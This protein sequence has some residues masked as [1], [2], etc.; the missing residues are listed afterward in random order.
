MLTTILDLLGVA[1]LGV[2]AW[3]VWPP[4]VLLVAGIAC[5]AIS[6]RIAGAS[7]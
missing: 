2:F 3:F 4:T 7:R 1:S 6:A 5:I